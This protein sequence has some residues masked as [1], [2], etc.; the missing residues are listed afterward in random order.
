MN[1]FPYQMQTWGQTH[2]S[3]NSNSKSNF[4]AKCFACVFVH[5]AAIACGAAAGFYT[6]N[7]ECV[8]CSAVCLTSAFF[9]GCKS[10][11]LTVIY[12]NACT[13]KANS[14][15]EDAL[16]AHYGPKPESKG[17]MPGHLTP[18]ALPPGHTA[19]PACGLNCFKWPDFS[20]RSQQHVFTHMIMTRQMHFDM[21]KWHRA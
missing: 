21:W 14:A 10:E 11:V 16:L 15:L 8:I 2:L 9:Y 20:P 17:V 5:C 13:E 12:R 6:D 7:D 3:Y 19:K 1:V 18:L 4:Q